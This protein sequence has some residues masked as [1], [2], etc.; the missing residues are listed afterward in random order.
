MKYWICKPESVDIK[1]LS[2]DDKMQVIFNQFNTNI[3]VISS[4][5]DIATFSPIFKISYNGKISEV[6]VPRIILNDMVEFLEDYNTKDI[7]MMDKESLLKGD[8]RIY[9]KIK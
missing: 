6:R 5:L 9:T 1:D 3:K 8:V 2:T 7:V 4:R